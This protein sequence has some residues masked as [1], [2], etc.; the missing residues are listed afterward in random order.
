VILVIIARLKNSGLDII[1]KTF[2]NMQEV[3]M[4]KKG[5]VQLLL[6]IIFLC[7]ITVYPQAQV[8]NRVDKSE[9]VILIDPGHGGIDGG[10]VGKDGT[11]EKDLNLI[12][13]KT[14]RDSLLGEGYKTVISREDD[15]SLC[16]EG[17]T[18]RK[19]KLED[20]DSRQK[21]I[22]ESNCN[23]FISI[24]LNAFPQHQYYGAQVWYASNKKS[25]NFGT[26]MQGN[27]KEN[28]DVNN[29]R[30]A[31]NAK[32]SFIILRNCPDIPAIIIECG[33]LSNAAEAEKLKDP[34]Y[35]QKIAQSIVKGVNMYFQK[36]IQQ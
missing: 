28:L 30:K 5:F 22:K 17:G 12:I 26:L 34:A 4:R 35:Q 18:I 24:H 10:A 20:L 9:K 6:L 3:A 15:R 7:P 25:E 19:K 13:G 1:K 27:L 16:T 32:E 11:L 36:E 33:F 23:M 31:K 2:Q 14:L 29:K 8:N 21:L